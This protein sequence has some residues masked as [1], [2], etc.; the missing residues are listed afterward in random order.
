MGGFDLLVD[1]PQVVFTTKTKD[2]HNFLAV[3]H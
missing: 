2:V 1:A 3:Y